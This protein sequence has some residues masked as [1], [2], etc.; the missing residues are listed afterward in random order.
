MARFVPSSAIAL[1]AVLAAGCA[2]FSV[3]SHVQQGLDFSQYRTFDW[4]PADGLP[5]GD[6]RLDRNRDFQDRIQGAFER[7]MARKGLERSSSDTP[8]VRIHYHATI[9]TRLDIDRL[10]REYGYCESDDCQVPTIDVEE[11]VLVLDVIDARTNALIWRGWTTHGVRDMLDP[12]R[13]AEQVDRAVSRMLERF[14][15][16]QTGAR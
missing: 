5:A 7:G 13:M 16:A 15:A 3:G 6:A 9:A 11:G 1:A 8:D 10:D 2:T 4:G 12:D 14:P